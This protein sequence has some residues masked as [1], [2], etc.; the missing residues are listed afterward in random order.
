MLIRSAFGKLAGKKL[1]QLRNNQIRLSAQRRIAL[2]S[3]I[4]KKSLSKVSPRFAS[5]EPKPL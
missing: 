2:F 5:Q 3:I 4:Q 1:V